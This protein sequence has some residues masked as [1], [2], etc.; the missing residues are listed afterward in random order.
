M[1]RQIETG[2]PGKDSDLKTQSGYSQ[3]LMAFPRLSSFHRTTTICPPSVFEIVSI[4]LKLFTT[5]DGF[6]I[7]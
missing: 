6:D 3:H 2:N 4:S 1:V 5:Y 7:L